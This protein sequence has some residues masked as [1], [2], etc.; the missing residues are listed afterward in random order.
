MMIKDLD[1]KEH[2]ACALSVRAV[3][4]F[5]NGYGASIVS[6]E[7][8]YTNAETPFE[9][10]VLHGEAICY[11]SGLTDDVFGYLTEDEANRVLA[12]IEALPKKEALCLEHQV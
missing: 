11:D 8:F 2:P 7:M 3:A 12:A 9:I 5:K 6:G 4:D 1:F 10:A